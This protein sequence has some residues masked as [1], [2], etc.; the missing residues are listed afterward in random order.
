MSNNVPWLK[1]A[2]RAGL[3]CAALA[4]CAPSWAVTECTGH[5][6]RVWTGDSGSIWIIMDNTVPW[7]VY[8]SDPNQKNILASAT[9]ALV[10]GL[11][12]SV[13]FQADGLTCSAGSA[14]G[15]VAGMW[16]IGS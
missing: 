1:L 6:V 15:D 10:A 3:A 4:L 8:Q 2:G 7:Y 9:T 12:V 16:L 14:R 5:V 13:R 11:S